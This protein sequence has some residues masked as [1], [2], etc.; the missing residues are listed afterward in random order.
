MITNSKNQKFS[1]LHIRNDWHFL[2][3]AFSGLAGV[4]IGLII[5]N[6]LGWI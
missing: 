6:F 4:G 1:P 3:T 5:G 2:P